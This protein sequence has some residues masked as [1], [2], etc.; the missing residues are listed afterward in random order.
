MHSSIQLLPY[1]RTPSPTKSTRKKVPRCFRTARTP[2]PDTFLAHRSFVSKQELA[3]KVMGLP[4]VRKSFDNVGIV[5]LYRRGKYTQ[6][7]EG[8][9]IT[10]SDST[11]YSAYAERMK[12]NTVCKGFNK[13]DLVSM[14]F[15]EFSE[16]ITREWKVK[17]TMSFKSHARKRY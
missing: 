11:E 9:L 10:Y 6:N 14:S 15:R 2:G 12:V 1:R 8:T 4:S 5:G 7:F 13:E 16:T 17:K 3:Y